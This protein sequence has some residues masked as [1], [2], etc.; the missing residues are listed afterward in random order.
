M[1]VIN[2]CVMIEGYGRAHVLAS[3]NPNYPDGPDLALMDYAGSIPGI[4]AA[5]ARAIDIYLG[6]RPGRILWSVRFKEK[7]TQ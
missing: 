5:T 3:D 7:R 1:A 4:M 6:Q 2:R